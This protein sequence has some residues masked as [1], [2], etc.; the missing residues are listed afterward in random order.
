MA[1]HQPDQ[2][3]LVMGLSNALQGEAAS[4]LISAKPTEKNW[5]ALKAEF[6]SIFCKPVDL[7]QQFSEAVTGRRDMKQDSPLIEEMLHSMRVTLNLLQNRESDE[8]FAVLVACYFGSRRDEF[9]GSAYQKEHPTDAKS[10]C[11]MLQGR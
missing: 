10:M 5:E 11:A 1:K 9:V 2:L 8:A 6:L 3:A 4:G 7:L